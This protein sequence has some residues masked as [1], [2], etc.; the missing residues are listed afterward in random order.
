MSIATGPATMPNCAAWRIRCA[1]LALEISFLLGMQAMLGQEPPIH[2]RST[3]AVRRPAV[4]ICQATSLPPVPLPST[5][6]SYR[7]FGHGFLHSMLLNPKPAFEAEHDEAAVRYICLG[8]HPKCLAAKR[9]SWA[10]YQKRSAR[11]TP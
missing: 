3:T 6:V 9:R 10:A 1:T 2:R 5:R 4:A 11:T 7:S 8:N